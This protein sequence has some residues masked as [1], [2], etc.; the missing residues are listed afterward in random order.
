MEVVP[1]GGL[2]AFCPKPQPS[3]KGSQL[4]LF[5]LGVARR[6]I[7]LLLD[8]FPNVVIERPIL[9]DGHLLGLADERIGK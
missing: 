9:A 2:S 8:R 5:G 7:D 6:A 4:T 1:G 3:F